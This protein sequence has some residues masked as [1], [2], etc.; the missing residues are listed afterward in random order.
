MKLKG[1]IPIEQLDDERLTNI[2]RKLVVAVSD[3]APQPERAWWSRRAVAFAG[4][5]MAV[6]LAGVVG[7]KLHEPKQAMLTAPIASGE[8]QEFE[9]RSSSHVKVTHAVGRVDLAMTKGRL[10]LSVPHVVGR[11]L[12]VHAGD[13]DIEDVGTKFSVDYDG[14][15]HVEVRVTEG[16]VN[17]KRAGKDFAVTA[18]NAWS[19]AT[20]TTT[21]A[22]LDSA[23]TNVVAQND[24]AT[25]NVVAQNDIEID[26]AAHQVETPKAGSVTPSIGS[27]ATSGSNTAT[28]SASGSGAGSGH[29]HQAGKTDVKKAILEHPMAG[30]PQTL[31]D[32]QAQLPKQTSGDNSRLLY[33]IAVKLYEAKRDADALHMI[34]GATKGRTKDEAYADAIWL[35]VRI[36]CL[37]ALDDRC[38][39]SAQRYVDNFP[40]GSGAGIADQILKA[41]QNGE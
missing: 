4:V 17:V 37:H 31:A 20:G 5:A 2:E 25:T 7:W 22:Q 34:E 27:N 15:G 11:L 18:S 1:R 14:A 35:Q 26:S 40:T 28:G 33:N 29:K 16:A 6:A 32:Y 21:I 9:M 3:M 8:P 36:T 38:R 41:I 30:A 19:T 12:V 10:E 13:T 39:I 24:S 23:S